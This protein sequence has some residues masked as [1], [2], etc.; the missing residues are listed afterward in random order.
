MPL[1]GPYDDN[2]KCMSRR[3]LYAVAALAVLLGIFAYASV[4]PA[5]HWFPRCPIYVLTGLKCPGCGSQRALHQLLHFHFRAAFGYNAL[6]VAS[7]PLLA[8]AIA[9][10]LLRDRLPGLR[11]FLGRR[12]VAW[13][14][15]GIIAA[16]TVGRNVFGF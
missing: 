7:L 14:L 8:F 11:A 9:A 2:M 12:V 3:L 15:V 5:T 13:V 16:W 4:D 1:G 6:V 10:E